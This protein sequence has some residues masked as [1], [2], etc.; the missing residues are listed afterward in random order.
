[1][2]LSLVCADAD[3]VDFAIY[4]MRACFAADAADTDDSIELPIADAP[5]AV[6]NA[7]PPILPWVAGMG[8]LVY[9]DTLGHFR[10]FALRDYQDS[11]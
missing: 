11:E 10:H 7:E 1:M 5:H 9:Q 2:N 3:P 6:L 8:S 4:R